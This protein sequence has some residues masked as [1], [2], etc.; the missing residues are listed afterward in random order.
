MKEAKEKVQAEIGNR[1]LTS[2]MNKTKWSEILPLLREL[3]AEVKLKWMFEGPQE[4]WC[5]NYCLPVDG[6]FEDPS[7]GPIPFREIEWIAIKVKDTEKMK[8]LLKELHIPHSMEDTGFKIWGYSSH[9]I[10]FV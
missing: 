3:D 6:Y 8:T 4:N 5:K 9:G 10:N 2:H 7:L 1:N